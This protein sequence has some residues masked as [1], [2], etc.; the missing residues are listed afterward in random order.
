MAT[1]KNA[2]ETSK[3]KSGANAQ[4]SLKGKGRTDAEDVDGDWYII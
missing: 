4:E 3:G 1:D 2:Q